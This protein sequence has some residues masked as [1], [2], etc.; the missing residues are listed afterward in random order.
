METPEKET[1]SERYRQFRKGFWNGLFVV[2]VIFC[3]VASLTDR[4][5]VDY[6]KLLRD[7]PVSGIGLL[8]LLLLLAAGLYLVKRQIRELRRE[9]DKLE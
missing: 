3:V 9:K 1:K 7:R 5:I 4:D 2:L 6:L 8:V